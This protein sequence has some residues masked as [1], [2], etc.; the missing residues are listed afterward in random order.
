MRR[1]L[2]LA[3]LLLAACGFHLRGQG[4]N[5][6]FAFPSAYV[7][8]A[9]GTAQQLKE[10]LRVLPQVTLL[11]AASP[12]AVQIDVV[13]ETNRQQVLTI[14]GAGRVSEYRIIY[15]VNYRVRRDKDTL[16]DD[17]HLSLF[18]DYSYDE[19]NPLGKD[20]EAALLIKDMQRDAA[21][22]I[23][24]RITAVATHPDAQQP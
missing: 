13:L 6:V 14:N 20:A 5:P 4:P 11:D 23:L 12:A 16:I 21:L 18:R 9:G 8:G 7:T 19:N 22:Q 2:I 24:R 15:T 3:T 17:G 10:L 1:L